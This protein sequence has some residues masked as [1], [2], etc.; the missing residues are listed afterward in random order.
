ME[1]FQKITIF[2]LCAS[3]SFVNGFHVVHSNVQRASFR[4][5]SLTKMSLFKFWESDRTIQTDFIKTN[6]K[7]NILINKNNENSR[8]S[9]SDLDILAL[10]KEVRASTQEQL[11]IQRIQNILTPKSKGNKI[12]SAMENM[13]S[14]NKNP[15]SQR[16]IAIA[17]ATTVSLSSLLMLQLPSPYNIYISLIAFVSTFVIANRDPIKDEDL[18]DVTG[19]ITR[20]VGRVAL[21]SLEKSKPKIQ[22]VARAVVNGDSSEDEIQYLMKR[23]EDLENENNQLKQWIQR[24]NSIDERSK[25]YTIDQLKDI[26]RENKVSVSGT[27]T[28]LMMRLIEANALDLS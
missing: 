22:A 14:Y 17:S 5:P 4:D 27:K 12:T 28:N 2:Y 11:D 19:P 24:R 23:I 8:N 26:A 21:Q 15:P 13:E 16:N 1:Q 20:T 25:Y 9:N 18:D 3:R 7:I 10:E 6:E